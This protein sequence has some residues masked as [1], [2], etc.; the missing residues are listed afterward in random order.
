MRVRDGSV[1]DEAA[2]AARDEELRA[3]LI[4]RGY[5]VMSSVDRG[6]AD[7]IA[8]FEVSVAHLENERVAEC[9]LPMPKLGHRNCA[10]YYDQGFGSA[11]KRRESAGSNRPD[12][13]A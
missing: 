12:S 10:R 13:R 2:L 1:H 11:R 9:P 6:I 4:N 5:R 8:R 7:Q 3:E